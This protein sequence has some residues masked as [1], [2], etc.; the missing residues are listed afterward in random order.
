MTATITRNGITKLYYFNINK[1]LALPGSWLSEEAS[2]RSISD[3]NK[4][5][6]LLPTS[7][8]GLSKDQMNV[9]MN[10]TD[11]RLRERKGPCVTGD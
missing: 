2:R 11:N 8:Q 1:E 10:V 7:Q 3:Y 6:A 5:R 4:E 9:I